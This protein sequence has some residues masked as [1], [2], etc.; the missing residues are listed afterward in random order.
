MM[1]IWRNFKN[2]FSRPFLT[3]IF[4]PFLISISELFSLRSSIFSCFAKNSY[5]TDASCGWVNVVT[6]AEML[7]TTTPD[8][9]DPYLIWK[10]MIPTVL[11]LGVIILIVSVYA[12]RQKKSRKKTDECAR[13]VMVWTKRVMISMES[14]NNGNSDHSN[15]GF[16]E[17]RVTIEKCKV[18][19]SGNFSSSQ[20]SE[21]EYPHDPKW[22]YDR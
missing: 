7:R 4:R 18:T 1:S 8:S 20:Y 19:S 3:I 5:G 12:A 21:Y 2:I 16:V 14:N 6:E 15:T 17:P 9:S 11:I 13:K 10:I 22:E